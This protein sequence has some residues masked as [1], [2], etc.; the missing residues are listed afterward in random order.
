MAEIVKYFDGLLIEK[1]FWSVGLITP[2]KAQAILLNKLI[3]SYGISDRLKVYAD[4][5][6]GFQGDECDI[7]FFIA[8]PN[9]YDYTGHPKCLLSKEYI[10]NVA[11]SRAKDYL[12]ILHPFNAIKGNV[13]INK[14]MAVYSNNFVPPIIKEASAIE[15]VLFQQTNYIDKNSYFTGHDNINVFGQTDMRYF[16]KSNDGAIDIQLRQNAP[17]PPLF[18]TTELG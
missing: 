13:F 7:V 14:L 6:H 12:I 4:T 15:S 18:N 8:N 17:F 1:D 16:I 3:T 2:Y 9:N 10:Y 5:V 11:I